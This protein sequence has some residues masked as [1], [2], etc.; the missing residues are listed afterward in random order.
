MGKSVGE[1]RNGSHKLTFIS[2]HFFTGARSLLT[3]GFSSFQHYATSGKYV[4][5]AHLLQ[6][7]FV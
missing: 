3:D 7:E 6:C 1:N 2:L 4:S 5:C